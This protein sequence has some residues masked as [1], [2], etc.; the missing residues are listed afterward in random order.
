ML[1]AILIVGIFA[2][3]LLCILEEKQPPVR[4]WPKEP[5]RVTVRPKWLEEPVKEGMVISGKYHRC[6]SRGLKGGFRGYCVGDY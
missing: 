3:L 4:V 6:K 5:F 2:F 1:C